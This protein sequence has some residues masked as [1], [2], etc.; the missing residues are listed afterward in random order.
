MG[1]VGYIDDKKR[2]WFCGRKNQRV[3]TADGTLFTIQCEGIFNIHP[4]VKRSALVG[5]GA[6]KNQKPVI[7]IEPEP[8]SELKNNSARNSLIK[9]LLEL[10]GQNKHTHQIKN[11]L[12]YQNFP[13]DIRHNA[14]ISREQL[15][16]WATQKIPWKSKE[17]LP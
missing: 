10:G 1:D 5:I 4:K 3:R 17:Q 6:N 7:V 12:I 9:E 2:L 13:V 8:F 15:A 16:Q 14:K 11:V